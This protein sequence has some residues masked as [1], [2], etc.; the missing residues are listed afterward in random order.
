MKAG[1]DFYNILSGV[2]VKEAFY[3]TGVVASIVWINLC[4]Q[5]AC[6]VDE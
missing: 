2:A 1:G 6:F 3:F 4:Y 5:K